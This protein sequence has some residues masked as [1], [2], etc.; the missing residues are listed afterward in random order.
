MAGAGAGD[1]PTSRGWPLPTR[2]PECVVRGVCAGQ[3]R[4]TREDVRS[5]CGLGHTTPRVTPTSS[6]YTDVRRPHVVPNPTGFTHRS[7]PT[8]SPGLPQG[9]A[10]PTNTG[11]ASGGERDGIRMGGRSMDVRAGEREVARRALSVLS[12]H[13][14]AGHR[15]AHHG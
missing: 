15:L 13:R 3:R 10:G 2:R 11:A 4:N 1:T 9:A 6:S 8:S 7:S 12:P 5:A 14:L